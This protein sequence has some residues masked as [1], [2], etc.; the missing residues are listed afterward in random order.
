MSLL[1][2]RLLFTTGKGGVGKS[3]VTAA[4][5][6]VAAARGKRV[7]VCEVNTHERISVL[8]GGRPAGTEIR[9]VA[10]GVDAVVVRP[11]ESMR[12]YA[13]LQ[14]KYKAVYKA[15][16]EN[17]FVAR[18]LR[19]IPSLPEL[20]MLGKILHHVREQKWDLVLVDAPATGHGITFLRVPQVLIDTV[21]PGAMRTD[22]E[23]MQA[24]L[25]DPAIT[26]V[27]L[28]S[29]PEELPVNETIELGTA[30]RGTLRMAPGKVFLNRAYEGRFTPAELEGL[31][32]MLEPPALDAA[33]NAARAHAIRANLTSRYREKLDGALHLPI[34]D[35]PFLAPAGDFGRP[36]IDAVAQ[37][38]A[39]EG[40][41]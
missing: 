29:L 18:F 27:N 7:L 25:V 33:A 19:F 14:L 38:L 4:L 41:L 3:T 37:L 17:R 2:R 30:V 12:E 24:L 1:D 40:T 5:A 16:F 36:A 23:W 35:I 13:L 8:L 22:A 21:P 39:A 32:R 26:A 15:V 20:V 11:Q 9:R 28:V 34:V 10:D 6:L 31:D